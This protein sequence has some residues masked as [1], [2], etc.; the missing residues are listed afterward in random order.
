MKPYVK[1]TIVGNE[2]VGGIIP[3]ALAGLSAAK[4]AVVGVAAGLGLAAAKGGGKIDSSH[5]KILAARK[6]SAT[7]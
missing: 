1:P 7:E 4:L 2:S 6:F 5:T 3:F